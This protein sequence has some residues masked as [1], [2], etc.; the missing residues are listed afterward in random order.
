MFRHDG[1]AENIAVETA[2][3]VSYQENLCAQAQ[4]HP[5]VQK[6]CNSEKKRPIE[7]SPAQEEDLHPHRGPD[8]HN[9]ES[10]EE[11][12]DAAPDQVATI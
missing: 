12:R 4:I 5:I 3:V 2:I 6:V 7:I 10:K 8:A 9:A 11:A 1:C